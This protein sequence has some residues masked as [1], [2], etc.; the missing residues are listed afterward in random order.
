M[1]KA[2]ERAQAPLGCGSQASG[3]ESRRI[4][5]FSA[6]LRKVRARGVRDLAHVRKLKLLKEHS[7]GRTPAGTER[8]Y[9]LLFSS[10]TFPNEVFPSI[11]RVGDDL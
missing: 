1:L 8:Y 3:R 11:L 5:L 7:L 6:K 10:S 9:F 2:R 4:R